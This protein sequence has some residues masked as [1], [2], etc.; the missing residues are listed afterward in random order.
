MGLNTVLCYRAAC[1]FV[2]AMCFNV[3]G[4]GES[5]LDLIFD[6]ISSLVIALRALYS[7]HHDNSRGS[8]LSDTARRH[9]V[10]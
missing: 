4:R 9:N 10:H 6:K 5:R 2:R 1:D 8:D 7:S 3:T